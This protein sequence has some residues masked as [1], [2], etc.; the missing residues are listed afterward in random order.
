MPSAGFCPH[1]GAPRQADDQFC[2]SCGTRLAVTTMEGASAAP[3]PES[4]QPPPPAP[5]PPTEP[6]PTVQPAPSYQASPPAYPAPPP[7]YQQPANQ[8]P[9]AYQQ[10]PYQQ[11]GYT[12]PPLY[13]PPPASSKGGVKVRPV[14]LIGAAGVLIASVLPWISVGGTSSSNAFDVPFSFLTGSQTSSGGFK[15]GVG[16]VLLGIAGAVLTFVPSTGVLRRLMG[17]A[18]I[19]IG[20]AFIGQLARLISDLDF[21]PSVGDALGIGVYVAIGGGVLLAAGK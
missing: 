6:L 10:Q 17:V 5:A 21:G 13:Q 3:G 20:A 7:T 18:A 11:P 8:P 19:G 4:A 14:P 2:G 9:G 15:V 1:C 12:E 16:L